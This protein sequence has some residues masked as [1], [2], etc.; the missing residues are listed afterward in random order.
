MS[1]QHIVIDL[2]T[3]GAY[4]QD[5][6]ILSFAAVPFRFEDNDSFDSLLKRGFYRKINAIEQLKNGR[7]KEENTVEWWKQQCHEA[8]ANAFLPAA[9][10]M[11]LGQVMREF[12]DWLKT[13]DYDMKHS[14]V[15]SRGIAFDMPKL[16]SAFHYAGI[17]NA[18]NFWMARDIRTYIDLL[19]GSERGQYIME[20]EPKEFIKHHCLHD[21]AHDVAIMQEIYRGLQ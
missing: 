2:E 20:H 10:D 15:W 14:W 13:T 21:C 7:T 1:Y 16:E 9:G 3:L 6:V 4:D 8:Q 5:T 17:D 12:R 11:P 18:V 19:T